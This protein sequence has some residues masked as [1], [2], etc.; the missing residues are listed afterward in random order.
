MHNIAMHFSQ[1]P[2]LWLN[3][4][5]FIFEISLLINLFQ[6]YSIWLS[7]KQLSNRQVIQIHIYV[8]IIKNCIKFL[9]N[10]INHI[11]Y[12]SK[13]NICHIIWKC[14][15]TVWAMCNGFN[16]SS[17]AAPFRLA[18]RKLASC[19]SQPDK[20]QFC[21]IKNYGKLH[22]FYST[23]LGIKWLQFLGGTTQTFFCTKL[24][25]KTTNHIL[26]INESGCYEKIV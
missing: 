26:V 8:K 23:I 16:I 25:I 13:L 18:P 3:E 7:V 10:E 6:K 22:D 17:N 9:C 5:L 1:M 14:H 20:S 24:I 4:L 21:K 15:L 12:Y 2:N 11:T 19:K